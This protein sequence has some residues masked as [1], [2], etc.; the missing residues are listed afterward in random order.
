[1]MSIIQEFLYSCDLCKEVAIVKISDDPNFF[2]TEPVLPDNWIKISDFH[3]C[4]K[5]KSLMILVDSH[6]GVKIS[7]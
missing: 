6:E 2:T 3:V 4:P 7:E 1:M 5:H